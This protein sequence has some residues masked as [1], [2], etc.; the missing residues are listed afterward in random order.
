MCILTRLARRTMTARDRRKAA[1][2]PCARDRGNA[3]VVSF[4]FGIVVCRIPCQHSD[5]CHKTKHTHTHTQTHTHTHTHTNAL[6]HA[7]A[8]LGQM[9]R[10][11]RTLYGF[12]PSSLDGSGALGDP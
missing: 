10:I 3:R 9:N 8:H 6:S 12:R 5:A 2:N 1:R 7:H 11:L 4:V